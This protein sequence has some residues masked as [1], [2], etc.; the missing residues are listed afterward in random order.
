VTTW[1]RRDHPVLDVLAQGVENDRVALGRDRGRALGLD[2]DEDELFLAMLTLRDAGFVKADM[3]EEASG[4][5]TFTNILVTGRGMQALGQWPLFEEITSPVTL[6]AF[7][8]RLAKQ[9]ES[10]EDADTLRRTADYVRSLSSVV[11]QAAARGALAYGLRA[12]IPGI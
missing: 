2:L 7:L 4:G 10:P 3:R 11:L 1:E 5:I 12:G 8:E 6:A 9:A